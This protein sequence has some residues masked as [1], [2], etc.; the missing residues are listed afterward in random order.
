[1]G[2][3]LNLYNGKRRHGYISYTIPDQYG[4]LRN[5]PN[6]RPYSQRL[7]ENAGQYQV[8]TDY[9]SRLV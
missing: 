4:V 3:W 1:M 9:R 8:V 2:S 5:D 6:K 7:V